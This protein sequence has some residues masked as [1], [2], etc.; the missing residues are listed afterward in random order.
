MDPSVF[1]QPCSNLT[2]AI[3]V[4]KLDARIPR[5]ARP[6]RVQYVEDHECPGSFLRNEYYYSHIQHI[7]PDG[8]PTNEVV[9]QDHATRYMK[10]GD[11]K[12]DGTR[13]LK[14]M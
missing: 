1:N 8:R 10:V 7:G 14:A 9:I 4:A 11:E 6:F 2:R 5:D 13:W 3:H 12:Y